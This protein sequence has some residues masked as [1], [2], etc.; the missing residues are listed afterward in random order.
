MSIRER[1]SFV[2]LTG[3]IAVAVAVAAA[4]AAAAAEVFVFSAAGESEKEREIVYASVCVCTIFCYFKK[5]ARTWLSR[6]ISRHS[7]PNQLLAIL[8]LLLLLLLL[9]CCTVFES[10]F[11]QT[12]QERREGGETKARWIKN[13][14]YNAP[15]SA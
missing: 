15:F 8:L 1:R 11:L 5:F 2:G 6:I 3:A 4:A 10:S 9:F 13:S 12:H 14:F 7:Q